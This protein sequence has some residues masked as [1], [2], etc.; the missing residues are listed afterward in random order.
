MA[1]NIKEY[2]E[3]KKLLLNTYNSLFEAPKRAEPVTSSDLKDRMIK[4]SVIK[5][6]NNSITEWKT[7]NDEIERRYAELNEELE[8]KV[9]KQSENYEKV[10]A[11]LK[12]LKIEAYSVNQLVASLS[13][14]YERSNTKYKDIYEDALDRVNSQAKRVLTQ[15]YKKHTNKVK[16]GSSLTIESFEAAKKLLEKY[17]NK[18]VVLKENIFTWLK[19]VWKDL[20]NSITGFKNARK[21]LEQVIAKT[22]KS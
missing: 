16:V 5:D 6:L 8:Q 18:K 20:V 3:I 11:L 21:E 19:T 10:F 4:P 1:E 15:L 9:S 7:L 17:T 14:E 22:T 12:Q 13:K 2:K